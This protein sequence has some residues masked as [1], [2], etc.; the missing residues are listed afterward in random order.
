[1]KAF[2]RNAVIAAVVVFAG[3]AVYLNWAYNKKAEAPEAA[4]FEDV[5]DTSETAAEAETESTGLYYEEAENGAQAFFDSARLERSRARD[6]AAAALSAVAET[7]GA[8]Q[9]T[10]DSA[11]DKLSKM[12]ADTVTE[13]ELETLICAKEGYSQCVVYLSDDSVTVTVAP[14]SQEGLSAAAAARITDTV[15]EKTGMPATALNIVEIK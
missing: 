5:T 14:L 11:L 15:T 6:E 2:K 9:E 13:A 3:A 10:I 12:A 8:S 7:E 4:V 1:M